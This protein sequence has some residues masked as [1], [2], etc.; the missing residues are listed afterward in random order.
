MGK[1]VN[2][3]PAPQAQAVE[4]HQAAEG[5]RARAR[6]TENYGRRRHVVEVQ[7]AEM[8][9]DRRQDQGCATGLQARFASLVNQR[10]LMYS[11]W[12]YTC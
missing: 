9:L 11:I 8:G 1:K 5:E 4:R 3:A 7:V 10:Q 6:Q 2:L 12:Q